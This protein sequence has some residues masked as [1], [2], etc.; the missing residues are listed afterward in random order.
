MLLTGTSHST[1]R[2]HREI[3]L[4]HQASPWMHGLNGK[5]CGHSGTSSLRNIKA[6]IFTWVILATVKSFIPS[7][8]FNFI[9]RFCFQPN[10]KE[11][12]TMKLSTKLLVV[13]R[14]KQFRTHNSKLTLTD[15]YNGC[16]KVTDSDGIEW[17]HC[18]GGRSFQT[19]RARWWYLVMSNCY[20]DVAMDFDYNIT[21]TNGVK[22]WDKHFSADERYILETNLVFMILY[23]FLSVIT[24][25]FSKILSE[26]RFLHSTYKLFAFSV[27]AEFSSLFLMTIA[28]GMYGKTG[29]PYPGLEM[30]GK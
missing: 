16:K 19:S 20:S 15:G 13:R 30:L 7:R 5:V 3:P 21:M 18:V 22:L 1:S 28:Y 23:F 17:M 12:S 26:R 4:C 14:R 25:R 10:E 29:L 9:D 24:M 11:R 8:N 2:Q 6:V 27:L